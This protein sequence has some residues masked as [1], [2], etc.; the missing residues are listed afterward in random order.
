MASQQ[1]DEEVIFHVARGIPDVELR[2]VY[3][4]QIC[5]GDQA[6]RDRV[7][8][9]L[10]VHERSQEFLGSNQP[11]P[12]PTVECTPLAERPGTMIG[13]YKL[14]EQIGEGGMGTVF[15]AEQ[16]APIRGG[17]NQGHQAGLG[18][19]TVVARFEAERQALA[20]MD[21]PNIAHVLDAGCTDTGRPYF[22]M[23]LV[24]GIPIT[25]LLRREPTDNARTSGTLRFRM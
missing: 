12:A 10:Q 2:S 14:L 16:D 5:A 23:E 6:L 18:L 4:G 20:L 24:K 9:L 7:E 17:G 11:E 15:V 21:H 22:V 3:L 1:L 13:R 8:A 25:Q 19:E